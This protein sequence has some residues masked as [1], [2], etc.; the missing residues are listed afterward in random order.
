MLTSGPITGLLG[1]LLVIVISDEDWHP[2]LSIIH[3]RILFPNAMFLT[4]VLGKL[5]LTNSTE[6]LTSD[7]VPIPLVAI[8][9]A[10]MVESEQII[11]L[12]PATDLVGMLP[13]Q[14]H[15]NRHLKRSI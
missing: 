10:R 3:A 14:K 8:F 5:L 9:P 2:P 15:D 1:E 4:L 7:Q 12:A 13:C 6:P 11:W